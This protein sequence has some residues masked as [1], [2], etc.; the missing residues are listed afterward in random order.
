M[1]D[2][3]KHVPRHLVCPLTNQ[4]FVDPVET[5]YGRVYERKA[6]EKHL[7]SYVSMFVYFVFTGFSFYF[8]SMMHLL[9]RHTVTSGSS[10]E[11]KDGRHESTSLYFLKNKTRQRAQKEN[12]KVFQVYLELVP[13]WKLKFH[14]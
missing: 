1:V 3:E 12:I 11:Y 8:Y 14:Q 2:V 6:I 5:K 7:K 13:H 10:T 4:M 9:T